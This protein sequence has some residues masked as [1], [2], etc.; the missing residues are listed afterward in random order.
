[1]PGVTLASLLIVLGAA[2][3]I[4]QFTDWDL[5]PRGFV[6]TALL[7]VGIGLVVSALTG[8]GRGAKGGLIG[9]GAILSLATVIASTADFSDGPRG[10]VGDRTYRPATAAAVLDRYEG[11]VGD[12]EI[13]LSLI[14]PADLPRTVE[15]DIAHGVGDVDV[16]VPRDADVH[17]S[18]MGGIGDVEFEGEDIG[19]GGAFFPGTGSGDWVDDGRAEFRI[20]IHNGIGDVEVQRA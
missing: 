5:G 1:V 3:L 14:D 2:V 17:V 10:D 9:L 18:G 19:Q 7:V 20:T 8:A 6:G 16:I 12:L 4:A 13:D 15:L 11:G